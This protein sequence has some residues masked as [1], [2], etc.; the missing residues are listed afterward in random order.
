[1]RRSALDSAAAAIV[2]AFV[3]AGQDPGRMGWTRFMNCGLWS[4]RGRADSAIAECGRGL[5]AAR[6]A[7]DGELEA[8][9]HFQLGTVQSRRGRFRLSVAETERALALE[10]EHG[11][12]RYQLAGVLNSMGIEYAAV[13]RLSEA[14]SLYQEGM[15]LA[16]TFGAPWYAAY[17]ASNL[18]Y[19]R[20]TIGDESGALGFMTESLRSAEQLAD[21][22]AMVYALNST[23]EFYQRSGNRAAARAALERASAVNQ[24]VI[25][26]YRLIT[27]VDQGLLE[28]ED[29]R[30]SSAEE[31]LTRAR[32]LADASDYGLQGVQARVGLSGVALARGER[33]TAL[34]WADEAVRI[35]DS[36][37][38]PEVMIDALAARARAREAAGR[39]DAADAFLAGIEL[40]ESWR[41][42]LALGD[43]AI[44]VADPRW[45]I[46]EGAI[47]VLMRRGAEAD[48]FAVAERGRARF[49]LNVIAERDASRPASSRAVE[50]GRRLR[51]RS[52]EH[53]S[54]QDATD[55]RLLAREIAAL[56]DSL[57]SLTRSDSAG[58]PRAAV[59]HPAPATLDEI[60][61]HLAAP[62]RS[63]LAFFW[64]DSAV[65]GWSLSHQGLRGA[66]LGP[67]D[68]LAA[69]VAFLV[70]AMSTSTPVEWT[71][72]AQQLYQSLL[73]PL[74]PLEET[75]VVVPDGPLA[76][77]PLEA[78]TPPGESPLG[79]THL[80]TYA[81]SASVSLALRRAA[82]PARRD[83]GVL[84][85][86]NPAVGRG[87]APPG[88]ATVALRGPALD[89]L[90]FAEEE[91]RAI[92]QL[93]PAE[94]STLLVG[95]RA[96]LERWYAQEPGRYRYL[97]FAAHAIV[98]DRRPDHTMVALAGGDLTLRDIR[99]A[100]L[101]A[102]L[103]T[104]SACETALGH[105]VR[106]EGVIGLPHAFLSAGARAVLVTLWR[107]RDQAAA[108]FMRELYAEIAGG[109]A[110]AAALRTVRRRWIGSEGPRSAPVSWASW[111]LVGS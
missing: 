85:V 111:I 9:L 47:R 83:R 53:A 27:L 7:G 73:A 99:Q 89:P 68:E 69:R 42:R 105:A 8:R 59:Q 28:L 4:R 55:R 76:R 104:L 74:A 88:P 51:Q 78:L 14:E 48:A 100:S 70:S 31:A 43:L 106:G 5:E 57:A 37:G 38:S 65:Y 95:R 86:G 46:Y 90:P 107:V 108:D 29:S 87:G 10:R 63:L 30:I 12:S 6:E 61:A 91:A 24:R 16:R 80:I 1:M 32:Q 81:P 52:D 56:T 25:P 79:A 71:A 97:H 11:R 60:T 102:E 50:L 2:Q 64:G 41:G 54:T 33:A 77:L 18:A 35:A 13:G 34:R 20:A 93:F 58:D 103:V 3:L 98:D 101:S 45:D 22:Q 26:L 21:T 92:Y 39:Q 23:A 19:L 109:A 84:A 94:G 17:L 49:L 110:P 15:S 75:V 72:A 62:G 96:T 36:L 67:A 40:L 82:Q 44:G 66:R